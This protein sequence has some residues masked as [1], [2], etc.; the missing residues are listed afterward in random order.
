MQLITPHLWFDGNADEAV[1]FYLD[2]FPESIRIAT[3][4]YPTEGLLDFQSHMAGKIL[5]VDFKLGELNF[6][7]INAGNEFRPNPAISFMVNFDPLVMSNAAE[8]LNALWNQ[9]IIDGKILMP[10]DQ[11]PFSEL[12]GW[13]EDQY[14][15]SWQLILTD[16]AGEPRP[17]I[18]PSFMFAGKHVNRAREAV[19]RWLSVFPQSDFGT[20]AEYPEQTGPAAAGSLMFSDFHLTGQWFAAMDSGV[21]QDLSFTEGVSLAIAC[22]NQQEIDHY[23]AALSRVP[24]SEVCGWCKDDFGVS[25]QVI[26]ETMTELLARP[27]GYQ[28]LM[29]MKKI[30][31]D[32]FAE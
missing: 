9:L 7:G 10:L 18:I 25:W 32:Q 14:G 29:T 30:D 6:V 22:K 13:V 11:Y 17:H 1:R 3:H 19:E 24:E 27:H 2:A 12:Y 4:Y 8:R 15:V 31:I 21:E 23:W 5:A 16:P 20:I 28:T 26:P